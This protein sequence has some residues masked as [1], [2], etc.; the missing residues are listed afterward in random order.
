MTPIIIEAP[1]KAEICRFN[2]VV[3]S[4]VYVGGLSG[5]MLATGDLEWRYDKEASKMCLVPYQTLTLSEISDQLCGKHKR[6]LIWVIVDEPLQ[7]KIYEY[8][9]HGDMWE[10]VGELC[11]YA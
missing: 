2:G 6:P 11:G 10:Q 7:G 8:G 9:N 5:L 4:S 3:E 1:E